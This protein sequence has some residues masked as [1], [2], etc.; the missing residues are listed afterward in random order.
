M[1]LRAKCLK[2]GSM[3]GHDPQ[4]VTGCLCDPD[5]PTWIAITQDGRMM[6]GSHSEYRTASEVH[7]DIRKS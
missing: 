6:A 4:R 2:C 1:I 5:A 7:D 3:I